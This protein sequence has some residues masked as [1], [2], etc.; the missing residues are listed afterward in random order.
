M[1]SNL[2][3]VTTIDPEAQLAVTQ[4]K[5]TELLTTHP[6]YE[7]KII[8]LMAFT[9]SG[10]KGVEAPQRATIPQV[11]L[12]QPSSSSDTIPSECRIGGMYINGESLGN[13]IDLIPILTYNIRRKWGD[14]QIECASLDGVKGSR[15]GTCSEC[16]YGRFEKGVSPECSPGYA[17][18][19][20]KE[21]LS[22]LYRIEFIKSSSKAGRNIRRLI[23]PPALWSKSFTI[24]TENIAGN[25][26]NYWA[27]KA[28]LTGRKTDAV[29][30][31]IC[32][33]LHG[34]FYSL[35]RKAIERQD[36]L[37]SQDAATVQATVVSDDAEV[38]D[39]SE[40]M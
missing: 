40:G 8:K 37:S 3:T 5:L 29:T 23:S 39:F 26:R 11:Y 2:A 10:I 38:V 22:G 25:N 31:E 34:F 6:E 7:E 28:S 12:R 4:E 1:S 27:F 30:A 35:Y 14:K 17:F 33:S 16:P 24:S 32:D 20:V 21:D 13:S 18:Y 9:T 15:Y 36:Q 19:A